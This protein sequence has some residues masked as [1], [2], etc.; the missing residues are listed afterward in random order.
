M[1]ARVTG[2]LESLETVHALIEPAPGLVLS[3]LLP[4]FV[5]AKVEDRVGSRVTLHTRFD[6]EAPAQG[7]VMTPR[8]VGFTDP[9]DRDF[10]EL[11][12]SVKGLGVRKALK[13]LAVSPSEIAGSIAARD[14]KAL[15]KLPEIGKRLAETIVAEL[16]GKV[17]RWLL[18]EAEV[19]SLDAASR[20]AP[21]PDPLDDEA[22]AALVALGQSPAEA[23]RMLTRARDALGDQASTATTEDLIAASFGQMP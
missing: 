9:A 8:L 1:I 2:R 18:A 22:V 17:D 20:A 11:F 19:V 3:V 23:N 15:T 12:T 5:R 4:A 6:L 7:S 10:F 14:A 13:A 16:H 21:Q